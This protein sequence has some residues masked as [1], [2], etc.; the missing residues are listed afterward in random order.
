MVTSSSVTLGMDRFVCTTWHPT[1]CNTLHHSAHC[2][3]CHISIIHT[4]TQARIGA[5]E[6]SGV[7]G[8]DAGGGGGEGSLKRFSTGKIF[9]LY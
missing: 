8:L 4:T 7:G 1:H 9:D 5:E 2:C 6:G 3:H